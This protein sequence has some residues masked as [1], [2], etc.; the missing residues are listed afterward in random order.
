MPVPN[1][2]AASGTQASG[3]TKRIASNSGV[4]ISSSSRYQP[5]S[6]PSGTPMP[7]ARAHPIRKRRMLASRCSE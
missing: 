2:S 3:A 5:I 1:H 4:T 7:T 6:N